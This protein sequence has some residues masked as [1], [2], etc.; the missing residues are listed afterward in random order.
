MKPLEV[1][2][3]GCVPYDEAYA[4]QE[5]L[6]AAHHAGVGVDT[7]LLLEHPPVVTL[8]RDARHEHIRMTP[9]QLD[10]LGVSVVETDRGGDATFH[11]PGQLVAYPILD[12]RPDWCD[13]RK[14]VNALERTMIDTLAEYGLCGVTLAGHPGVWL[15]DAHGDRKIGAIGA[16]LRRWVTNHGLALNVNTNLGYFDCIVPCGIRDKGVTSLEFELRREVPM[17]EVMDK[18]TGHFARI[19][20]RAL[21]GHSLA[22]H[23]LAY[24]ENG[25]G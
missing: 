15:S 24:E 9:A 1:R 23:S 14:F 6:V 5:A 2:R 12:L 20:G 11:G 4:L 3:L 8:G 10:A 7:L 18:L 17:D 21:A 25:H 19:F 16:R 13:I 22:G